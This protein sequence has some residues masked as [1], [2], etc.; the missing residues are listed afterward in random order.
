MD[1]KMQATVPG[2]KQKEILHL[3]NF[4]SNETS[5]GPVGEATMSYHAGG[6]EQGGG[7]CALAVG[8]PKAKDVGGGREIRAQEWAFWW[9]QVALR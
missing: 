2:Y 7:P 4:P 5:K 8:M 9:R 3:R 6:V 1:I